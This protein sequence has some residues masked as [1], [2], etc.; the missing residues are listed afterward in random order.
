MAS[1][2]LADLL[3]IPSDV[4]DPIKLQS[5][6][7]QAR[8]KLATPKAI[9][10][11][12]T[13]SSFSASGLAG[14]G[15]YVVPT[16]DG[17]RYIAMHTQTQEATHLKKLANGSM[18]HKVLIIKPRK[19]TSSAQ[20]FCTD[21]HAALQ[22]Q[23][24]SVDFKCWTDAITGRDLTDQISISLLEL[25]DPLLNNLSERDFETIRAVVLNSER[26]LWITAGDNPA[27]GMVDGFARCTMA[28]NAS[29]KFQLLHLSKDTGLSNG[30]S[31]VT[32]ILSS[33]SQDDEYREVNG[34]LQVARIYKSTEQNESLRSHLEDSTRVERLAEQ[35]HALRLIIGKPGLLDTLKFVPDQRMLCPLEDDQVDVQ[36]KATSL[37]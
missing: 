35:D 37:K 36:V 16:L 27:F 25:E 5:I 4:S 18:K 11:V 1:E 24:Y 23:G 14:A 20:N 9:I 19:V 8:Q 30:P 10:I 17:E 21:L 3:I 15:F 22:H 33:S 13:T 32:R 29:I 7:N 12:I 34:L 2:R 31:L 26:L 28:E 6:V